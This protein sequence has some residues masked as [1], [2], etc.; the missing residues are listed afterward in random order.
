M[1]NPINPFVYGSPVRPENFIGRD[2]EIRRIFDQLNSHALGSVAISGERRIGKTSLLHYVSDRDVIKRWELKEE[3]SIF[4][5]QDCGAIS[6]FTIINFW[7]TIATKVSNM[8]ERKKAHSNVVR[9][10][11]KLSSKAEIRTLDIEIL[12]DDLYAAGLILVLILDEFE[13]CVRADPQNEPTTRDFLTGLRALINCVP[14]VFSLIVSTRQPLTEVCKDIRFMGSPFYNNFVFVYLRP[15]NQQ[16]AEVLFKQIL[17]NTRVTFNQ[18]EK[19]LI[20]G[21]AGT[22]PL[23]LQIA[24]ALVFDYKVRGASKIMDLSPIREQFY[25]LVKHQFEEFWKFSPTEMQQILTYLAFGKNAEAMAM[26]ESRANERDTLVKRGLIVKQKE[27]YRL[28]SPVFQDWLVEN[29]YRRGAIKYLDEHEIPDLDKNPIPPPD[30][31]TVF[32][33]YSHKD[34][35]EKEELLVHLGVL[36]YA[37][38]MIDLWSDNRIGGGEYWKQEIIKAMS[39]AKVA[40]FLI[41]ANFL[42]SK[43]IKEEEVPTLIQRQKQDGLIVFP[44]IA[45]HCAW[46]EVE[47]L[48]QMNVRPKNGSPVWRD[49]GIHADEELSIIAEQVAGIIK[50][51]SKG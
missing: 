24:A 19:K 5:F 42:N 38:D 39:R 10:V 28:F 50:A 14:R 37:A 44:I 11:K 46:R 20:Y 47:W 8:L 25:D 16:E 40:I 7:Q 33:S 4:I 32:I 22:H 2:N 15:F 3:Q 49:G 23:L 1:P 29:F 27:K 30:S 43:F 13:W 17:K 18:S 36:Q 21:L 31:P 12:L 6:P 9:A 41:S 48:A 51:R 45:R 34:E 35:V 26:L